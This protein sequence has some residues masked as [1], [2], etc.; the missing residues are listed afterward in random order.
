[1]ARAGHLNWKRI[2]HSPDRPGDG[3]RAERARHHESCGIDR[4]DGGVGGAPGHGARG[5]GGTVF[6]VPG[7]AQA[8]RVVYEEMGERGR[9]DDLHAAQPGRFSARVAASKRQ[10][11]R[12]RGRS[13]C[14]SHSAG[15]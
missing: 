15:V 1:M 3:S 5:V 10:Y 4:Q 7:E 11:D 14:G 12:E 13:C 2:G 6:V 8:G 9:P